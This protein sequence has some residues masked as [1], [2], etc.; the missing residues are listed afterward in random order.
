MIDK[1]HCIRPDPGFMAA[2]VETRATVAAGRLQVSRL[3]T[4]THPQVRGAESYRRQ[5]SRH[6]TSRANMR[7]RCA[8][9]APLP[10]AVP[11]LRPRRPRH[12]GHRARRGGSVMSQ[13][14][15]HIHVLV[16]IIQMF[17]LQLWLCRLPEPTLRRRPPTDLMRT[18]WRRTLVR[19]TR[20]LE[21][22]PPP[23]QTGRWATPTRT[24]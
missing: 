2:G 9:H 3:L 10:A 6:P 4:A 13:A 11:A 1:P 8:E 20:M 22:S 15:L 18:A 24:I 5:V 14:Q 16:S 21:R 23:L 7:V 12:Q 19:G 17:S